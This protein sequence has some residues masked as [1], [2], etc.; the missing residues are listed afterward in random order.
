VSSTPIS[1]LLSS[2]HIAIHFDAI[3]VATWNRLYAFSM[4]ILLHRMCCPGLCCCMLCMRCMYRRRLY[5]YRG[6]MGVIRLELFGL[7]IG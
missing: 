4:S 7:L 5:P 3:F 6:L 1:L 2:F